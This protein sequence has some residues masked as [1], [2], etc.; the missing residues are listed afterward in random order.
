[1]QFINSRFF[2]LTAEN[3]IRKREIRNLKTFGSKN[4]KLKFI[5]NK[6]PQQNESLRLKHYEIFDFDKFYV[7]PAYAGISF[8]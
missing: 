3:E 8:C 6:K 2:S 1:M 7:I 4:E 5:L